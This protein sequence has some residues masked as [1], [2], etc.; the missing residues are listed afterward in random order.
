MI[1]LGVG[2]KTGRRMGHHEHERPGRRDRRLSRAGGRAPRS[3]IHINNSN[4]VLL[5]DS[6]ERR[7]A[8]A[9]GLGNRL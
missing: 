7:Q 5:D 3:F 4:P 9:A 8:E 1:R 6:P 2:D